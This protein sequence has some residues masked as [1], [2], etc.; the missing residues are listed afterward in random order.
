[1]KNERVNVLLA[2]DH[3][4]VRTGVRTI[5]KAREN[6]HVCAEAANGIEAV[7]FAVTH[8]PDIIVL[9]LEMGKLDGLDVTRQI[10]EDQPQTQVVIFTMHDNEQLIREV[11]SAGAMAFTLKSEGGRILI[12]AIECAI[13]RKLF[14]SPRAAEV[15]IDSFRT[16]RASTEDPSPLTDRE[17][18]IVRLLASG[19][20]NKE[21]AGALGIS[22]KTVEKHRAKI[23]RK[24]GFKSIVNLVRYAVREHFIKA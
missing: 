23:M 11:L 12:R 2:D 10:K 16:S 8:R 9:D 19:R 14:L 21:T 18:E 1:M 17:K 5:L 7:R 24:L 13:K 6:W 15:L 3:D 4:V 22:V 20:S